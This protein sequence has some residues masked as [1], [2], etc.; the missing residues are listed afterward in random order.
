MSDYSDDPFD[1]GEGRASGS[2]QPIPP[3]DPSPRG[4]RR[5]IPADRRPA[6]YS[7]PALPR[8]PQA[9][10]QPPQ[11]HVS[12][13]VPPGNPY[14]AAPR[15]GRGK[16]GRARAKRAP[17][18]PIDKSRSGLYLPWWSLLLLLAFV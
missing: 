4:T 3:N 2:T 5:P 11:D 14:D 7:R 10:P 6:S 1:T 16:R 8:R 13:P 17:S 15:Q 18:P 12:V 9:Q